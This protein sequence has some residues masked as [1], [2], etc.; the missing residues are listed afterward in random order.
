M[1]PLI[2]TFKPTHIVRFV[3]T[4]DLGRAGCAAVEARMIDYRMLFMVVCLSAARLH[5]RSPG[6]TYKVLGPVGAQ[7]DIGL[8]YYT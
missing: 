2:P 7:G 1:A 3:Q 4:I 8:E 6:S 5:L